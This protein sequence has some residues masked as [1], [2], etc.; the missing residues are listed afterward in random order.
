MNQT[1]LTINQTKCDLASEVT[2]HPFYRFAQFWTF[3]VS[4]L[5]IPALL[6]FL[7]KKICV[8]RFHGNIKFMLICYFFSSFLFATVVMLDFGYHFFVPFFA[9]S[10]CQLILDSTLFKA[11]H[12]S[13]TLFM[14]IPML[15]PIGF[16]IERFVALGM[17]RSYEN[18]RTLLGPVLV[19]VLILSDVN[20]IY[21]V[22][23]NEK[24]DDPFISFILI[25]ATSAAQFNNFFWFLLYV[26]IT[27]FFCNCILL[28]VHSRLKNNFRFL[29]Q[30]R[31]LSV[32]YELEEISQSSQFTLIVSF[33]HLL[34][35]GWYLI[36]IIS[37]RTVG[38]DFFGGYVPYTVARGVYCAVPTYNLI[39]VF[40]GIKSLQMMNLRR[41]NKVQSTVQMKTT[42][43]EGAKNYEVAISNYWSSVSSGINTVQA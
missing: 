8:L 17:A 12:L 27:N 6:Y 23:K 40:V 4:L 33:T 20:L 38:K 39:I 5:A 34:F 19:V 31:T 1:I 11:G 28:L 32:R 16:S 37:V 3:F 13:M 15:L 22:F 25:P 14:T 42:G 30:R 35:V 43:R 36:A 24:F 21:N 2:F 10:K 41:H 18:V 26:E 29:R 9:S 7:V